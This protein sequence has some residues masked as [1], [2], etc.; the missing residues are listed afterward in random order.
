MRWSRPWW[1]GDIRRNLVEFP[2]QHRWGNPDYIIL[3]K[4]HAQMMADD[5]Y[6]IH[7]A[8]KHICCDEAY[9]STFF[10]MTGVLD[11]FKNMLTTH[12][13]WKRGCPYLFTKANSINVKELI[14]AKLN[15]YYPGP[16][17]NPNCPAAPRCCLFA[18]KISP[19]FPKETLWR[20]IN[21]GE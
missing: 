21:E 8:M 4:K 12:A 3:N 20:I 11:E 13:N 2:A 19:D 1:G 18:R 15:S 6:W 9:P 14:D 17:G 7:L 16:G 5:D 10:S